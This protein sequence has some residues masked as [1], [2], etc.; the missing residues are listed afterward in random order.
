MIDRLKA[1]WPFIAA[2][3]LC[4]LLGFQTLRIEGLRAGH[5]TMLG[6]DFWV[7]NFG[8]FKPELADCR[9]ERDAIIAAQIEAGRLQAAVNEDE[10][11]RTAA[12]AE[13]SNA[14]HDQDL[15]RAMAA[16]RSFA[17]SHRIAAGELRTSGD[18]STPGQALAAPDRGGAGLHESLPADTFVAVS[19]PDVQA[20]TTAVTWAVGAYNWAQTLPRPVAAETEPAR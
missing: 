15:A 3:L 4:A 12:N 9:A 13:R 7:I 11:R 2:G 16:G 1:I 17:D 5:V 20:C 14:S 10:E 18:R 6:A 19:D 8:G